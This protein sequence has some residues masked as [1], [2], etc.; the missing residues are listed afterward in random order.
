MND[1]VR[2]G[3]SRMGGA[4]PTLL[5]WAF[6]GCVDSV[7]GRTG[8][9]RRQVACRPCERSRLSDSIRPA[10]Q[11]CRRQQKGGHQMHKTLTLALTWAAAAA[12]IGLWGTK[13][14]AQQLQ[15]L[16][17]APD[18]DKVVIKTTDLGNKT[19]MLEGEGGNITVAVA[20]D[21]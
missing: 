13:A 10:Q 6:D 17:P 7:R 15:P 3:T 19:Y 20:N 5:L 14:H 1:L 18:F 8:S 16:A 11:A 2:A 12:V 9:T 21:G 4:T